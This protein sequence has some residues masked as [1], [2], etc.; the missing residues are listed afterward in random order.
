MQ[1]MTTKHSRQTDMAKKT[2]KYLKASQDMAER[3]SGSTEFDGGNG[4]V[5]YLINTEKLT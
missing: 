4:I 2:I 3:N 5:N 1:N